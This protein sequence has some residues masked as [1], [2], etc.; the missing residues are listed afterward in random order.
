MDALMGKVI[1]QVIT[2][3]AKIVVLSTDLIGTLASL[4]T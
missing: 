3:V 4:G 2:A 1:Y